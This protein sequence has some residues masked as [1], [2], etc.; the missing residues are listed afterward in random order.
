MSVFVVALKVSSSLEGSLQT[1]TINTPLT[2][3]ET[4]LDD[5]QTVEEESPHVSLPPLP[6]KR[7]PVRKPYEIWKHFTK[8]PVQTGSDVG[9]GLL[10]TTVIHLM[11]VILLKMAHLLYATFEGP[12][13]GGLSVEKG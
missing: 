10:A 9:L 6:P 1:P 13:Q 3:N 4:S 11:H 8:K 12:K 7:Q 2:P 5:P